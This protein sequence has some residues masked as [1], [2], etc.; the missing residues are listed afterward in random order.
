MPAI[1]VYYIVNL[2]FCNRVDTCHKKDIEIIYLIFYTD[3]LD[4]YVRRRGFFICQELRCHMLVNDR[5][6]QFQTS[7]PETTSTASTRG[8]V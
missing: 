1:C 2:S 7:P 5:V 4:S 8:S 6:D 3:T